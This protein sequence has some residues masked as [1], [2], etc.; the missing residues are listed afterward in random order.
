MNYSKHR[1]ALVKIMS[2]RLESVFVKHFSYLNLL[3]TKT[4]N[5][6]ANCCDVFDNSC[7]YWFAV[8][9]MC[10]VCRELQYSERCKITRSKWSAAHLL[11]LQNCKPNR[12]MWDK[13]NL[14]K[15]KNFFFTR[16]VSSLFYFVF[17]N[18]LTP[19]TIQS[20]TR[21]LQ[22]QKSQLL[23]SAYAKQAR[24][25]QCISC[26][27]EINLR[28]VPHLTLGMKLFQCLGNVTILLHLFSFHASLVVWAL[29]NCMLSWCDNK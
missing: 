25:I 18:E 7:C 15:H 5:R 12:T 3:L 21:C 28:R 4:R 11:H 13:L 1:S 27:C 9:A 2:N 22:M 26:S 19:R 10:A 24:S 29:R 8:H 16:T 17:P 23:W 6:L 20:S 14:F